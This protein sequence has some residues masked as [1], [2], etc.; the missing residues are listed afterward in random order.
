MQI[1][2]ATVILFAVVMLAMAIGVIFSGKSL[3]GSCGGTGTG[4]PCSD[5]EKSACPKH[6]A[7][8]AA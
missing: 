1:L 4:C 5:E 8:A 7:N 2:F 3:K 6:R